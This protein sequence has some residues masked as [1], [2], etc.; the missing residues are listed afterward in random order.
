MIYK[1]L[2]IFLL[3]FTSGL[4]YILVFSTI[5][6][7]LATLDVSISQIGMFSSITI[8]YALKIF[9]APLVDSTSIPL[10]NNISSAVARIVSIL[11]LLLSCLAIGDIYIF[12][13]ICLITSKSYFIFIAFKTSLADINLKFCVF[14][15]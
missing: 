5:G 7:W 11:F 1:L 10:F 9:W 8:I 15:T 3:G 12:I 4:P 6:I 13:D 2:S 14:L